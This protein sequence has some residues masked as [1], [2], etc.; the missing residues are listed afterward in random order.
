M[1]NKTISLPVLVW[2]W[3]RAMSVKLDTALFRLLYNHSQEHIA[4]GE[5]T[6]TYWVNILLCRGGSERMKPCEY[7][8][9]TLKAAELHRRVVEQSPTW[10]YVTTVKVL[11]RVELT[12]TD[13]ENM[14]L[15]DENYQDLVHEMAKGADNS[16]SQELWQDKMRNERF[17]EA[18][19]QEVNAAKSRWQKNH[20]NNGN[21]S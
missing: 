8:F 17:N 1:K 16:A 9:P 2:R 14:L 11:S 15:L 3:L 18:W 19:M 4:E 13:Y 5:E 10:S 20:N 21:Q 6:F 12:V 7:F